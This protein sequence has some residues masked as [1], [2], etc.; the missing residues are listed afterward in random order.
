MNIAFPPEVWWQILAA[1]IAGVLASI[2]GI[3]FM[4]RAWRY[5]DVRARRDFILALIV[6]LVG[7][8]WV[9]LGIF[10]M[11]GEIVDGNESGETTVQALVVFVNAATRVAIL[12]LSAHLIAEAYRSRRT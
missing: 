6:H 3:V 11:G 1:M 7:L 4:H 10:I 12:L 2:T 9:C 8:S 5:H